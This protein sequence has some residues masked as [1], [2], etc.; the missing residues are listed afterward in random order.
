M[1]VSNVTAAKSARHEMNHERAASLLATY[2]ATHAMRL[3]AKP[4]RL[5]VF[6]LPQ[7]AT[8]ARIES[9]LTAAQRIGELV[10]EA[11]VTP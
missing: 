8:D 9:E 4:L 11:E 2:D 7:A 10:F 6:S 3:S 5:A 1:T